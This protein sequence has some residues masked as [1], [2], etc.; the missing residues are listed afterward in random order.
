MDCHN[1]RDCVYKYGKDQVHLRPLRYGSL[2]DMEY[3]MNAYH[4]CVGGI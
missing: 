4:I 3:L 1:D 2:G